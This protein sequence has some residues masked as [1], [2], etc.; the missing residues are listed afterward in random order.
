M[1]WKQIKEQIE[2]AG[3]TDDMDL[4]YI[5]ISGDGELNVHPHNPDNPTD[6]GLTVSN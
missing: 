3:V 2:A 1:T 5:D 6:L 4:W